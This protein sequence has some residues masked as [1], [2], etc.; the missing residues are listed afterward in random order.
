LKQNL[1]DASF[2][3]ILPKENARRVD[4]QNYGITANMKFPKPRNLP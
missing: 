3:D 2:Q 1:R 4:A